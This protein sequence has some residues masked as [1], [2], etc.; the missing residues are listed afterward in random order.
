M[1]QADLQAA[2]PAQ[3]ITVLQGCSSCVTV[4]LPHAIYILLPQVHWLHWNGRT[5][6]LALQLQYS[7]G[8]I[9]EVQYLGDWTV[10][11]KAMQLHSFNSW[12]GNHLLHLCAMPK[13]GLALF[14]GWNLYTACNLNADV[15]GALEFTWLFTCYLR[16]CKRVTSWLH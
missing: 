9:L 16:C 7:R 10:T 8:C 4:A 13:L 3:L 14:C 2:V 1:E 6:I 11:V 5:S 12:D 15:R